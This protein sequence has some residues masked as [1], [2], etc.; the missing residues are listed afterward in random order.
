MGLRA[1]RPLP[2]KQMD[3][4]DFIYQINYQQQ[5]HKQKQ[6]KT[7]EADRDM[8]V[9]VEDPKQIRQIL[10][11][12]MMAE[13]EYPVHVQIGK[14]IFDY[15]SYLKMDQDNFMN[16]QSMYLLMEALDPPIGNPRM[17]ISSF[18]NIK[19]FT[20]AYV[21]GFASKYLKTAK[22]NLLKIA[23]PD[24]I[25]LNKEKRQSVRV[26]VREAWD[27]QTLITRE[28]GLTFPV[29][30]LDISTGGLAFQCQKDIPRLINGAEVECHLLWRT[31]SL[32]ETV[33][34]VI[35]EGFRTGELPAYRG[36]FVFEYYN[37][38]LR[39]VERLVAAIQI[40]HLKRRKEFTKW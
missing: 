40:K 4:I 5:L 15:F 17:R 6:K 12:M 39:N 18:I 16:A 28:A 36:R 14:Q 31:F 30:V 10:M 19:M 38:V 23:V 8:G 11:M 3:F 34:L 9:E 20:S 33:N 13:G 27:M 24:I 7:E 22:K 26:K 32:E 29:D 35:I 1:L 2:E 37:D 25:V 21:L